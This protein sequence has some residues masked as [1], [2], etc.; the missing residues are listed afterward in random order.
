MST[1]LV[2]LGG[3]AAITLIFAFT[4]LLEFWRGIQHMKKLT[5]DVPQAKTYPLI[6]HFHLFSGDPKD[7]YDVLNT[8]TKD[9]TALVMWLGHV[10]VFYVMDPLDI[11]AI[12]TNPRHNNK[13]IF[14]HSTKSLIGDGLVVKEGED[15]KRHRKS[16][17]PSLHLDI[18]KD[19]VEVFDEESCTFADA[20]GKLA[21]SGEVFDVK[22]LCGYCAN[23]AVC[24]TVFSASVSDEEVER[25]EFVKMIMPAQELLMHRVWRPWLLNDT[26]Y[27]FHSNYPAYKEISGKVDSFVMTVIQKKKKALAE[28]GGQLPKGKRIAFL[29]HM[30]STDE[31][32]ALSTD[33][34]FQEVKTITTIA[35]GSSMDALAFLCYILAL[36]P[37][38]QQK[39]QQEVDDIFG[40]DLSR[41]ITSDDLPH[42]QFTERFIKETLRYFPVLPIFGRRCEEDIK[43]P[44][45]YT[46]PKGCQV[47][48]FL[49]NLT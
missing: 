47:I 12:V 21:D 45:G 24:K 19:F 1:T 20:L 46:A 2:L 43:L 10:C 42:L 7:I 34:L 38:M 33:E 32:A 31:G 5:K 18:L 22:P 16:M 40:G 48:F 26:L 41:P 14:Y 15:Y 49:P 28:N 39:V 27:S 35:S 44:S 11:E 29:D 6:G 23:T 8:S 9:K 37:D 17:T 13:A 25:E 30:L 4:K 36:R 3:A